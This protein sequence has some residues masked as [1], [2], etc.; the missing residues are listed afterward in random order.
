MFFDCMWVGAHANRDVDLTDTPPQYPDK[1][2]DEYDQ[3]MNYIN[4]S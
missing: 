3:A 1:P 4:L 2:V